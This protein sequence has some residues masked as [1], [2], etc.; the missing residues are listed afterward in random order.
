MSFEDSKLG[1]EYAN[2]SRTGTRTIR[3]MDRY[4]FSVQQSPLVLLLILLET[5]PHTG[6]LSKRG[7]HTL[8]FDAMMQ[9]HIISPF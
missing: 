4:H 2:L 3:Q 6:S 1:K 8:K 9:K 5:R 7:R